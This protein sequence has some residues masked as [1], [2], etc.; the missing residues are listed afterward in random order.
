MVIITAQ[1]A[2]IKTCLVS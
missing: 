1:T 2:F